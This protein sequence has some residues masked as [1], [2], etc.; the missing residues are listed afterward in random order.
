VAPLENYPYEAYYVDPSSYFYSENTK[1]NL[2]V[3]LN[4]TLSKD[5]SELKDSGVTY[6]N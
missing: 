2:N 1:V 3:K 5:T 4:Y 6:D